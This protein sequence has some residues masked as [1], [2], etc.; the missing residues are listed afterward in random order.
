MEG[1]GWGGRLFEA[2]RLLTFSAFSMG[3]YSRW[4]LIR[5]WALIRINTVFVFI[6][7]NLRLPKLSNM[8]FTMHLSMSCKMAL[9]FEGTKKMLKYVINFTL[10]F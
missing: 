5:G 8:I 10:F 2:G 1:A 7:E 3:A 4:A 9:L 6:I